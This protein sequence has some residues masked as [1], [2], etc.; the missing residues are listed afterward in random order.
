MCADD[1]RLFENSPKSNIQ[2]YSLQ[3]ELNSTSFWCN[4]I[5]LE[6]S[7]NECRVLVLDGVSNT[8]SLSFRDKAFGRLMLVKTLVY[9]LMI[10]YAS[11][12]TVLNSIKGV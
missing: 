7:L 12:N 2:H 10:N 8:T 11:M 5:Q 4:K 1:C 9:L 6:I 3:E